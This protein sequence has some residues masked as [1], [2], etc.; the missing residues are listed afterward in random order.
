MGS[1]SPEI[2]SSS[3]R[4]NIRKMTYRDPMSC[5]STPE[6]VLKSQGTSIFTIQTPY[7]PD[8]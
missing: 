3:Q 6:H 1:L 2:P 4:D 7:G 8:F 5:L